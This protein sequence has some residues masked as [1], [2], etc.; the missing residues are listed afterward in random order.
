M[1]P[2]S[3]RRIVAT[4]ILLFVAV[5]TTTVI[6][7]E[8]PP[9]PPTRVDSVVDTVHGVAIPDPYRWLED[10]NSPETRA[11][12]DAQNVYSHSLLDTISGRDQLRQRFS[13]L[14]KMDQ[15]WVRTFAG[16]T[17]LL[18]KRKADDPF[19]SIYLRHGQKG[20]DQLL[21][22][23]ISLSKDSS[24]TPGIVDLSGDGTLLAYSLRHGGED[25][26]VVK[27]KDLTTKADMPDSLPRVL[28][29][30]VKLAGD[31]SGVYYGYAT[32]NGPRVGYHK[33]G[34]DNSA[35]KIMF[36]DRFDK[37]WE[38]GLDLSDNGKYLVAV[39]FKGSSGD[40][41]E[42]YVK[43]VTTEAPFVTA[44]K[45]VAARF[46]PIL[47]KD[48]LYIKTNWKAANSRL[49]ATE[50]TSPAIENWKEVVPESQLVFES[51]KAAGN[52]ILVKYLDSAKAR[53]KV[54]NPDGSFV[55]D[56][57]LPTLGMVGSV[58]GN[59]QSDQVFVTFGSFTYP[60]T[61]FRYDLKSWEST[62]FE[63][64][65]IPLDPEKFVVKQ[66]WF[67]SKDGTPVPMFVVHAK[68][69]P[70][71]GN[72][73]VYMTGYGGFNA[74]MPPMFSQWAIV[75]ME[76]GGAYVLVSLRGG[77]EFGEAWHTAGM[78]DKKQNVFDD[79]YAGA[80][81][82]I[83]NMYTN[84][85]RICVEGGSNGGLLVGAA[86]T[87][88]PDLFGAIICTY[89]LLDM[90][91]YDKF[92]VAK[93]WVPEYGSADDS[94]QFKYLL[95]YS[96]YHNVKKGAKY[97]AVLFETGDADTRVAPLH[98]RKMT[99][100]LQSSTGSDKP[101]LLLYDTKAGHS[102]GRSF[103]KIIDGLVDQFSFLFWQL[104]LDH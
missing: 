64:V 7:A 85:S 99:A 39:F 95:K 102:G 28:Y 67:K 12:I 34:A 68:D 77:G 23:P 103:D 25:E 38:M 94:S 75:W 97:P 82:L 35:D 5:C 16:D 50:Y 8:L 72:R 13:Q 52:F 86:L 15:C 87:Q 45:G 96:P 80:E 101:V 19:S 89:P 22:D 83:A 27:F 4:I 63:R 31:K 61:Q 53:V 60:W 91:R 6:A 57:S 2:K 59:T 71:D 54:F 46:E 29:F 47:G 30:D 26:T 90:I 70:L 40:E 79:L 41:S 21:I 58:I 73:P 65:N 93:Y 9:P 14:L 20:E 51:A 11:W 104:N 18:S 62:V 44:A 81:W 100:L 43:D 32:D 17:Y 1:Q 37:E 78:L 74:S 92:L 3:H 48:K 42:L 10:Q 84:P 88:R 98:A 69:M 33:F 24:V 55:R 76:H 56:L 49:M 66:V 36:G